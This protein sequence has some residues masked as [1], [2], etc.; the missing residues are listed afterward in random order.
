M[1]NS[2][3]L[4]NETIRL[5]MN[6]TKDIIGVLIDSG[7]DIL[8]LYNGKDFIYVSQYHVQ[9]YDVCTKED[10]KISLP[11]ESLFEEPETL[12]SISL[13]K[14]LQESKGMFTE[15]YVTGHHSLHGYITSIMNDY[16]VFQSPIHKTMYISMKH[17]KWLIPYQGNERPYQLTHSEFPVVPIGLSLS[18][19]L[20]EQLKKVT[21]QIVIFDMYENE[22]K[23]G[24]LISIQENQVTLMTAKEGQVFINFHHVKCVHFP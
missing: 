18:R 11:K 15:I 2:S 3:D 6:G 19:T 1:R 8:V 16:F 5:K 10:E 23:I 20:E 9:H 7:N 4:T 17:L 14:A 21:N 24:K 22:N 13:R 12:N